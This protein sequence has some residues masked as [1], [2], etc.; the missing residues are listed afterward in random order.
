MMITQ[1]SRPT[2]YIGVDEV[3]RGCLAGPVTC[4]AV[5]FRKGDDGIIEGL[6]DSKK[7]TPKR[8]EA[9]SMKIREKFT[10]AI[11]HRSAQQIDETNILRATLEAMRM[12]VNSCAELAVASDPNLVPEKD[13]H[14]LVDGN[15][16]I[17]G[18]ALSQE[19]VV[20]GDSLHP[21]ISAASIVAKVER[22]NMMIALGKASADGD[23]YGFAKHKGYGTK[24]HYEALAEHG[25]G[26]NHRKTFRLQGGWKTT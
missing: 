2:I 21:V 17:P 23:L 5:A 20:K 22:D 11:A 12:A 6:A 19:T 9:L 15:H 25:P 14:V 26:P 7:L 24:K 1:R 13:I 16:E 3:G 18:L 8:R 4:C 10:F